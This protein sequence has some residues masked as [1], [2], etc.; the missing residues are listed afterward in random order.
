MSCV[1][2]SSTGPGGDTGSETPRSSTGCIATASSARCAIASWARRPETLAERTASRAKNRT[3]TPL[4]S[5]R[6]CEEARAAGRFADEIVL[7][8]AAGPQGCAVTVD[9]D[10][11]PRDGVTAASLAKLPAGLQG[12]RNRPR[13]ELLRHHRRRRLVLVLSEQ[14]A[15]RSRVEPWA[16]IAGYAT[17]GVDPAIMGIGPVPAVRKLEERT[18]IRLGAID[19]VELNEAFA[20]QVLAC[21]RALSFDRARST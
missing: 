19:L 5:Q 1:P 8:V 21:D 7:I 4:E 3:P 15:R 9:A 11:H 18:G 6:R 2:T 16:R 13:R 17:A 14:A 12:G 10:E 20:A